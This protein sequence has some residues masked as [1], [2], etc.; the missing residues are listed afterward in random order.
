MA[1]RWWDD[2]WCAVCVV[3]VAVGDGA[4]EVVVLVVADRWCGS[5]FVGV[6]LDVKVGKIEAVLLRC[7]RLE[8]A[9]VDCLRY[10]GGAVAYRGVLLGF[11]ADN[12]VHVGAEGPEER[13]VLPVGGWLGYA[14]VDSVEPYLLA[15]GKCAGAVHLFVF[16]DEFVVHGFHSLL[17]GR[18]Y[19][20]HALY[21]LRKCKGA[22][23]VWA[24]EHDVR[25]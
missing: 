14:R 24:V 13:F 15:G 9:C 25:Y 18:V 2:S 22:A 7:I 8:S 4:V 5:L 12:V 3:A 11:V 17:R 19:V 10:P 20:V 16:S 23:C 6:F 1:V 21:E